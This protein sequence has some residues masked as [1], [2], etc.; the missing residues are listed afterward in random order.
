MATDPALAAF[1]SSFTA[2]T[3]AELG[4]KTFFVAMLL[5]ARHRGRWVFIGAFSALAAVTL[6][7]LALGYG[8]RELLPPALV[9]WL[10]AL[11][12]AGFGLKLL[13]DAQTM[14][15]GAAEQEAKEAEELVN[16]AEDRQIG[17]GSWAVIRESFVLVFLAE[18]G[19]RTQFATIALATAPAFSFAGL[20]AGTLA[21]HGLVTG[22]AVGAGKWI[23]RRIQERL[24]FRL[25]G[26]L[27]LCF[28]LIAIRQA[29]A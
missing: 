4:D 29:L 9:P 15:E 28:A 18:L 26:G 6:I 13:V 16:R 10:A 12:F 21:G 27:F 24:L 1:G 20:L 23:G 2:I 14:G 7:S 19:D 5:A 8:L 11:L 3:L 25:S 22:L 17:L